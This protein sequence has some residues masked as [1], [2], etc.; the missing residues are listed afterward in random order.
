MKT[1][2]FDT[3]EARKTRISELRKEGMVDISKYSTVKDNRSLFCVVYNQKK[4]LDRS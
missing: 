2:S 3:S 1:E 4:L